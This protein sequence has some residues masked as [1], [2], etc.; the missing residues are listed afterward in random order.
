MVK[1]WELK[2][3]MCRVYHVLCKKQMSAEI[4]KIEFLVWTILLLLVLHTDRIPEHDKHE[5]ESLKSV[6]RDACLLLKLLFQLSIIIT[7]QKGV[8]CLIEQVDVV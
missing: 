7:F 4:H 6:G 2:Q 8:R 1:G 5:R 3:K